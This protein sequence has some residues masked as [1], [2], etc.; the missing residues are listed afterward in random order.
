MTVVGQVEIDPFC[1][2]ILERH[3]P[4]V[5]RHDDVRTM[6]DW[7]HGEPRPQVDVIAGGYPCQGE[8]LAGRRRGVTDQRWLWP[9]MARVIAAIRPRWMIG[10]NVLGHRTKGLRFV[11]RDLERL[12]YVAR[13]GIVSA[14]E[15]GAPHRRQ[16]IFCLAELANT[17]R[18][19]RQPRR[20]GDTGQS[21]GKGNAGRGGVSP[22]VANANGQIRRSETRHALAKP[23]PPTLPVRTEEPG[24][25]GRSMAHPLGSRR[26]PR[27]WAGGTGAPPVGDGC[28]WAV[29]PDVGRVAHGVPGRVDRLRALGNAVVP[30]VSE[31]VGQLL[32]SGAWRED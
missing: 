2:S 5:P 30:Q 19:T 23:G 7:W 3:W 15:M 4:G 21:P 24:G 28:W 10:E 14:G 27:G 1:R 17:E 31:Y 26:E 22:H 32:L 13:A 25:R 8:S 16:R 9:E 12:G 20:A 29:E 11:L 18:D 6:L